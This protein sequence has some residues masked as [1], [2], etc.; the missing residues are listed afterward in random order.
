MLTG[1]G[2]QEW[3]KKDVQDSRN[4]ALENRTGYSD[5]ELERLEITSI[6]DGGGET[7]SDNYKV[8]QYPFPLDTTTG[9]RQKKDIR[10]TDKRIGE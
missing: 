1:R 10:Y 7:D 4:K 2:D 3:M 5:A 6:E 9:T 8:K